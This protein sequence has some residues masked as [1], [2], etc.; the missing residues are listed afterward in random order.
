MTVRIIH[1]TRLILFVEEIR[2]ICRI[3]VDA[4]RELGQVVAADREVVE[5][6]GEGFRQNHVGR[7]STYHID[8]KAVVAT[9]QTI[10]CH[11]LED[12]VGLLG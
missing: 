4:E 10:G 11:D 9:L 7:D 2:Q 5:T 3:A 1:F 6:L 12:A 8:L